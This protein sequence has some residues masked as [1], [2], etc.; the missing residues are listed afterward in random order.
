MP[1]VVV[2]I[3]RVRVFLLDYLVRMGMRMFPDERWP[4]SVI[5][6][7]RRVRLLICAR[8]QAGT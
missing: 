2:N 1:L 4:M 3:G 8:R 6:S 5:W 7:Q